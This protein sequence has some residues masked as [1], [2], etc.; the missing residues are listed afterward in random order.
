MLHCVPDWHFYQVPNGDFLEELDRSGIGA[1]I[2]ELRG[3]LTQK[4]F[5]DRLEVGRTSIVRYEA[6]ERTPDAEFIARVYAVFKA[7]P[8]WLLTGIGQKPC[9][10]AALAPDEKILLENFRRASEEGKSIIQ[11]AGDAAVNRRAKEPSTGADDPGS[12]EPFHKQ[13]RKAS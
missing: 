4:E 12:G 2:K 3:D 8:I 7:D 11:G 9:E 5:A 13:M 10:P 6:G 1:R